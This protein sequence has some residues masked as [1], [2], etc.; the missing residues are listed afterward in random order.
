[1]AEVILDGSGKGY[2]TKVDEE[3]RLHV[4]S[5]STGREES[6][7]QRGYSF[8]INSGNIT[9][10][11]GATANGVLYVRNNESAPLVITNIF[12]NFG[13]ST[14]GTG[15]MYVDIIRNP[16]AG[17]LI[18]GATAVDVNINRNFGSSKTLDV[19][20]YKGST[21]TT[22]TDGSDAIKSIFNTAAQR[23]AISAGAITLPKGSSIGIKFT[24]PTSNT[25][26]ICNFALACYL[27][28]EEGQ[29]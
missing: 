28:D 17:T 3:G 1:M 29:F 6:Q 13:N 12:Y 21:G 5:I 11:N 18:S 10:T 22:I 25:S 24:T 26:L 2:T 15:N 7:S 27:E 9:L 16:M 20:A 8:N 19:I 23:I 4:D 14:N